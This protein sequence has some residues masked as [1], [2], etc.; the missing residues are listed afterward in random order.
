MRAT[1]EAGSRRMPRTVRHWLTPALMHSRPLWRVIVLGAVVMATIFFANV[2][3]A[4]TPYPE[5]TRYPG[6]WYYCYAGSS[7]PTSATH[8]STWSG[9][10]CEHLLWSSTGGG[11]HQSQNVEGSVTVDCGSPGC[12]YR[13]RGYIVPPRGI[14]TFTW[15]CVATASRTR[16]GSTVSM[17]GVAA[18]NDGPFHN[19]DG[20]QFSAQATPPSYPTPP[21]TTST[22]VNV[23]GTVRE[24]TY[25]KWWTDDIGSLWTDSALSNGFW[26]SAEAAT[27][28]SNGTAF[29]QYSCYVSDWASWPQWLDG[30]DEWTPDLPD[31]A[32][33]PTP[34]PGAPWPGFGTVTPLLPISNEVDIVI[35]EP[36][37]AECTTIIPSGGISE[38]VFGYEIDSGWADYEICAQPT[39]FTMEYFGVDF[40]GYILLLVSALS[41][42]VVFKFFRTG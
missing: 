34:V 26:L 3:S 12:A 32:A 30:H 18:S 28:N 36:G 40:G 19:Q 17:S 16:T 4:Q 39:E 22:T 25:D 31:F 42:G 23:V 33:T 9:M 5:Q 14:K 11:A 7:S 29:S 8:N 6:Y 21:N 41:V 20:S 38:T 13:V 2:A 10:T 27:I 24:E 1:V 35:G 37:E 15:R